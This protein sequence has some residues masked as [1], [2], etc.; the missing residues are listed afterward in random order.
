M[1][2]KCTGAAMTPTTSLESRDGGTGATTTVTSCPAS[3]MVSRGQMRGGNQHTQGSDVSTGVQWADAHGMA[4]VHK[5][6]TG[7]L[8]Y[9]MSRMRRTKTRK[10]KARRTDIIYVGDFF[11]VVHRLALPTCVCRFVLNTSRQTF[12]KLVYKLSK[13]CRLDCVVLFVLQVCKLL[14]S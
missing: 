12:A 10:P 6:V 11:C 1:T 5:H 14:T 2:D 13:T 9:G 7:R 4:L 3:T 8:Q